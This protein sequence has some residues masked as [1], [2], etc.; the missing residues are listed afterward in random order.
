MID[1]HLAESNTRYCFK[2][3]LASY[4]YFIGPF[5]LKER[6]CI[7][8]HLNLLKR[9]PVKFQ[10]QGLGTLPVHYHGIYYPVRNGHVR[11]AFLTSVLVLIY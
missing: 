10:A 9:S 8:A 4:V 7:V 2:V 6:F 5:Y 3:N 1:I 11:H